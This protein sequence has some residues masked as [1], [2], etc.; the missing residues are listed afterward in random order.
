MTGEQQE[1]KLMHWIT[2]QTFG[3]EEK[4][5]QFELRH[6]VSGGKGSQIIES[7]DSDVSDGD[8]ENFCHTLAGNILATAHSDASGIG[9]LQRYVI[10]SYHGKS[11]NPTSR[12]TLAVR[13]H[14]EDIDPDSFETEPTTKTGLMGQMMRHNEGIMK[15]SVATMSNAM[16]NLNRIMAQI[17]SVNEK[18]LEDRYKTIEIV[19]QLHSLAHDRDLASLEAQNKEKMRQQVF[20]KLGPLVPVALSKMTGQKL[21]PENSSAKP[22]KS[23]FESLTDEQKEQL[24]KNFKHGNK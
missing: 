12:Y 21:L 15:T 6:L 20:S 24:S 9:G 4:C 17:S 19:E 3:K 22:L 10:F 18:L 13:S 1:K 23:F 5:S 8:S 11:K 14:D 16:S 2:R 7:F